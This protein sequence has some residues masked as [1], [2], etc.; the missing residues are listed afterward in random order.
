MN[1]IDKSSWGASVNAVRSLLIVG[2]VFLMGTAQ[3]QFIMPQPPTIEAQSYVLMDS[4]TKRVLSEFNSR[5]KLQPAS[6]TKIMTSYVAAAE[7]AAGRLEMDE[8]VAVSVTA[9][10]T[11]GSRMFIQEG[12]TVSVS[13]LLR[14]IIVQSGNDAS[15]ALAEHISGSDE[16]FAKLMNEYGA[17]LE[18]NDTF[19][20]N[21]TGL[22]G[23]LHLS[24]AY[25][26]ALLARALIED[27]PDHYKMYSEREFT[28]NDIRQ[29]NRNRLLSL[30]PTVDG[31]KTGYTVK[32]GYCLVAS[33]QREGMRLIS[34]V[35]GA[36]SNDVRIRETRKLFNYGFRNFEHKTLVGPEKAF[37]V[38]LKGG[39]EKSVEARLR[40]DVTVLVPKVE[41]AA[42]LVVEP[43]EGLKAPIKSGDEVG[44]LKVKLGDEQVA[45]QALF[46]QADVATMGWF[47]QLIEAITG[48]FSTKPAEE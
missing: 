6:L 8:M 26:N 38:D 37:E 18:L 43:K 3:A 4:K 45:S 12:T 9:W 15:V 16:E 40:A 36:E 35:M 48:F 2:L 19:F 41:T 7:I 44:V 5:E 30:D 23:D 10:R 1:V 25:D 20:M 24:T 47:Q 32:A 21:S 34:V 42:E 28:Y 27:Y 11:E 39:S 46:A 31:V 13:D 22:P 17:H 33:A 29:P 14:G